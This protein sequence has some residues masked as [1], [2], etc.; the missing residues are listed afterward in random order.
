MLKSNMLFWF[1]RLIGL[2]IMYQGYTTLTF[3]AR[4]SNMGIRK[5]GIFITATDI[6]LAFYGILFSIIGLSVV[7]LVPFLIKK[8]FKASV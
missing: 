4:S 1:V 2:Y 6:Q 3:G 8:R 7:L 5:F